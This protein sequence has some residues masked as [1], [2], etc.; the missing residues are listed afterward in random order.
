M[1]KVT[2]KIFL[3][4]VVFSNILDVVN[5]NVQ[6]TIMITY[7]SFFDKSLLLSILY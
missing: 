1:L 5:K 6:T 4:L 3:I 2:P 7:I